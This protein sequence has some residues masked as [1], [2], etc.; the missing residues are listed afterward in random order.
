MPE[1][2]ICYVGNTTCGR[3]QAL[4]L[5]FVS[6]G[7]AVTLICSTLAGEEWLRLTVEGVDSACSVNAKRETPLCIDAAGRMD[8][9]SATFCCQRREF[10]TLAMAETWLCN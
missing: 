7:D 4:Q 6:E 10:A 5:E 8:M 3:H 2:G 9:G 1:P